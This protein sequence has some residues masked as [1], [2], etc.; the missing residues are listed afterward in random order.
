MK[1]I[2]V[3]GA[4][5]TIGINVIKYL[6]SEGKYN[7][8]AIDLPNK[9]AYNRLK[10]YHKRINVVYGDILDGNTVY[11]LIKDQDF[12][13]HLASC[14]PPLADMNNKIAELVE[15][16]GTE[17]IVRAINF[18]NKKC[19]LIFASSTS[20]YDTNKAVSISSKID[21]NPDHLFNVAKY[22]AEQLITKHLKNYV[23]LRV[24]LVIGNLKQNK[25]MFNVPKDD[26]VE[27]IS[28]ED[29]AYAFVKCI[30]KKDNVNKKILNIGGGDNC[31]A[32]FSDLRKMVLK[33]HGVDKHIISNQLFVPKTYHS[34]VLLDSSKSNELLEYQN[35]SFDSVSMKVKRKSKKRY[36][37][38]MIGKVTT[39][40]RKKGEK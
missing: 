7:I 21:I 40:F 34:P 25:M 23:I 16:N 32:L 30:D 8:T 19:T 3:T 6:L 14:M 20:I 38:K 15:V 39:I 24:P 11:E 27:F 22:K 26:M 2:L 31:T 35:D 13:I 5:G 12:I 9:Y 4:A 36:I 33:Y 1:K 37:S 28:A 17:N 10:K 18:Y 29:A